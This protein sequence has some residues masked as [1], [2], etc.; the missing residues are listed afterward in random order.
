MIGVTI[1]S[2]REMWPSAVIGFGFALTAY[3]VF[4]L[5]Y[6]LVKLVKLAL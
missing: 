5:G 1:M 3:W 6:G 4:F 2:A